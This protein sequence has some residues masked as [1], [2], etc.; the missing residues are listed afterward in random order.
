MSNKNSLGASVSREEKAHT[1]EKR[2]ERMPLTG[3]S[4]LLFPHYRRNEAEF[5]Y[6]IFI[7]ENSRIH[8]AESA[9]YE[10]CYYDDGKPCIIFTHGVKHHLMRLPI[11]YHIQDNLDKERSNRARLK[12]ESSVDATKG[13][14]IPDGARS[15]LTSED[16]MDPSL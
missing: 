14:Y 4:K 9:Y 7:D 6:H 16:P 3:G 13:E 5:H 15:T 12:A 11:A 10:Q 8:E 2:P 1:P